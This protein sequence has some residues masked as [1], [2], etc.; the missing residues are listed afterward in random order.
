VV[1]ILYQQSRDAAVDSDS[2]ADGG[3]DDGGR[4]SC[5]P[6]LILVLVL[7]FIAVKRYH[8]HSNSCKGNILGAGG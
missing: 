1:S 2:D 5:S 8:D 6:K 7:S 3:D 4:V